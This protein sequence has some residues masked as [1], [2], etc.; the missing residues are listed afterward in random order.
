[1]HDLELGSIQFV[2]VSDSATVTIQ[3]NTSST[4]HT[5]TAMEVESTSS[6]SPTSKQ[7][8]IPDGK[9]EESKSTES[10]GKVYVAT[11]IAQERKR[12]KISG[13]KISEFSKALN[14]L[15]YK[16]LQLDATIHSPRI[17]AKT[18][19]FNWYSIERAIR[20]KRVFIF[21]IYFEGSLIGRGIQTYI[22]YYRRSSHPSASL[23]QDSPS[24]FEFSKTT[25]T[26]EFEYDS[27]PEKSVSSPS[28][29]SKSPSVS[30]SVTPV[31]RQASVASL[32]PA[33]ALEPLPDIFKDTHV[34]LYNLDEGINIF[35]FLLNKTSE[36]SKH[37]GRY[38][39]A[40][41]GEI[42]PSF[43]LKTT[44]H[45]VTTKQAPQ[46]VK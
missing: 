4:V 38:I 28:K 45:I 36:I 40:F 7:T 15:A 25:D 33:R 27:P 35:S 13:I 12:N 41:G 32:T 23:S 5:A 19:D 24:P 9:T 39:I 43:N 46:G 37:L 8:Q 1:M 42:L 16:A 26:Q 18:P 17:G 10:K 30:L 44:S 11:I 29:L 22:Y 31:K 21:H 20:S 2:D 34:L 14:I 6:T 3:S